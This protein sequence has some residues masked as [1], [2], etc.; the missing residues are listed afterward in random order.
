MR[1]GG[2]RLCRCGFT[3]FGRRRGLGV[4]LGASMLPGWG[5]AFFHDG[6]FAG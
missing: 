3:A 5:F 6:S 2:D 1:R 4:F